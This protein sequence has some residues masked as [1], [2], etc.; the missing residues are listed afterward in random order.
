MVVLADEPVGTPLVAAL[1]AARRGPGG[2][3]PGGIH[4]HPGDPVIA[5][6]AE[7]AGPQQFP[8]VVVLADEPVQIP[9]VGAPEAARRR[10]GGV[11]PGGMRRHPVDLVPRGSAELAGPHMGAV[12]GRRRRSRHRPHQQQHHHTNPEAST[13]RHQRL[14]PVTPDHTGNCMCSPSQDCMCS[15]SQAA[16]TSSPEAT[17]SRPPPLWVRP[18]TSPISPAPR[19]GREIYR[20]PLPT[21]GGRERVGVRVGECPGG[22]GERSGSPAQGEGPGET[23]R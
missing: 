8:V 5:G 19:C 23:N 10:P 17:R 12:S 11:H 1:E 21:P 3:H 20:P 15:P 4:R 18:P 9:L 6:G 14:L 22:A 2:V 13:N 16:Y 7:L